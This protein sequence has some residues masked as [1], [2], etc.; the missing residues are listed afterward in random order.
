[1]TPTCKQ[2]EMNHQDAN[3][4]TNQNLPLP[5]VTEYFKGTEC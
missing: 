4:V 3:N 5:K 2:P 1:M